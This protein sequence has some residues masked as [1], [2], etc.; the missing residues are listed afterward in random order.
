MSQET[1]VSHTALDADWL[2][3][4]SRRSRFRVGALVALAV[5]LVFLGGV[6]VQKRWGATDAPSTTGISFPTGALTR[7]PSTSSTTGSSTPAVIGKLVRVK[8]HTWTVRDLGGKS[9][10]VKVTAMT[11]VTRSLAQA[12]GPIRTG[13]SITVLGKT[14][15]DAVAA[16]VV[17]IR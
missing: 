15:G 14:H 12:T 1:S 9:H 13:T 11:T 10:R 3:A 16:T 2:A 8:G 5:L 4:P 6:E 17:T 7:I